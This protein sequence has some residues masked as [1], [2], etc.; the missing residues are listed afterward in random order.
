MKFPLKFLGNVNVW[1]TDGQWHW[2]PTAEAAPIGAV[3]AK[4]YATDGADLFYIERDGA[5]GDFARSAVRG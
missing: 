2:L 5:L 3:A 1:R 4:R